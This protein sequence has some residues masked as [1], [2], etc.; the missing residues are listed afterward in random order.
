[1]PVDGVVFDIG[2]NIGFF[3]EVLADTVGFRGTVHLFEPLRNLADLCE[4]NLSGK[5]YT[6][7]VHAY[8]LGAQ[9]ETTEIFVAADG[10]LGWNTLIAD[11]TQPEMTKTP[12]AIR[13][14]SGTGIEDAPDFVKIDVEGAEYLVLRGLLPALRA[15][16]TLPVILCEIGWGDT[17]PQW[18]L[19]LAVFD[20]LISLG[21]RPQDLHGAPVDIPGI[22]KTTDVLLVPTRVAASRA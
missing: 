3:T 10:N 14:F 9:D 16:E 7:V 21:Y 18:D 17:H 12:I 22:T 11:K 1:M 19:E 4:E 8:G 15:W 5:E 13:A 2:G 20:E 6:A